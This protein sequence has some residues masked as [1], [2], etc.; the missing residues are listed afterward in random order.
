MVEW[1]VDEWRL[2]WGVEG[3]GGKGMSSEQTWWYVGADVRG[4]KIVE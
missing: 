1:R 4:K 3:S 2:H